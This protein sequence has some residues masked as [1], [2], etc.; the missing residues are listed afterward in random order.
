M[1][2]FVGLGLYDERSITVEGREALRAADRA[3]AEFY[4]SKL[5]GATV[6]ELESHHDTE[7]EVRDRAGEPGLTRDNPK[8]PASRRPPKRWA[9]RSTAGPP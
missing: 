4:T 7:I 6:E 3:F 1:L 9:E 8:V 5:V 2:T